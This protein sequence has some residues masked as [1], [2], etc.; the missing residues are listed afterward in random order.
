MGNG[1]KRLLAAL[2]ALAVSGGCSATG[3]EDERSGRN[4]GNLGDADCEVIP[5]FTPNFEPELAWEWTGSALAP[6]FKQVIMTPIVVEVNGD[7]IPDIVFSTFAGNELNDGVLRAISGDDGHDLWAVTN[8]SHSVKAGASIAAGDIDGDGLVEICGIPFNGRGIIC[9]EN[10]GTFKFRSAED[11]YDYNEWGGPSLADLDGDGTVEILDGNRVY[12]NTGALKWVGSDGMGGAQY[13]GPVSFGADIDQ[14]GTQELVNGRSIYK[15]DGTLLC[16][17]TDIP[18]GTAAVGNFD[19]D[20]QG[21][22]VVAGNGKVSL[23]DDNCALKW[24][25]TIPGGCADG[26]GGAPILADVDSDGLPEVAVSGDRAFSVFDTNGTLKWTSTIQDWSSGKAS[27]AVFDFEDDGQVELVFA[28]E[29]SLRIYNGATGQVRFETRHSSATTHENPVIADV[30]GDFAAD[31]VV[32]TNNTAYPP[33]NGIRVYHDR[34]EGWA[35]TRRIWNQSAYSITNVNNDG[36]IPAHPVSHWL[37]PKLNSFHG[38]A[39]NYLGEGDNPYAAVDLIAANVTASCGDGEFSG[40]LQLSA[41]VTNQGGVGV[42]AGVKVSF[43]RGNPASGGTLLGT[44]TLAEAIPAN[45]SV[46][47]SLTLGTVPAGS[48]EVFV[49]VDDNGSGTGRETECREDNNTA[50]ATVDLTCSPANVPPVALCQNVTVNADAQCQASASVDNGSHDP[51]QQPGP[52][53]VSQSPNGP[54]GLGSHNV[55]LTANDGADSAQCV[56]TVTVVDTTKPA[57]S[58]PPARVINTCAAAGSPVHYETPSS[59]NCGEAPVSCSHP[60]GSTFPPGTTAVSC[61]ATDGSG[62]ASTCGFDVTVV[63]DT[64]PPTITCPVSLDARIRL[65]EIGLVLDFTASATDDCGTPQMRCIPPPGS[66]FLLGLTPVA[67]TATDAA[68]NSASC[69]F[70]IRVS[71]DLSLP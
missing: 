32:A 41:Q 43:Y 44:A 48:A 28:D 65:G 53:S 57:V 8:P 33:Y 30:D 5:P 70:G 51:D 38:N 6:E 35:R 39:A 46:L 1:R 13:T 20:T 50:S 25:A 10:D 63:G 19:G 16:A 27:A 40:V 68:G 11:A 2:V 60:S 52:F 7:G 45:G 21:E 29:V 31:L 56:G 55:T 66:L 61:S 47:A 22:I 64:T 12:S 17:N 69:H 15:A 9:Y 54:F 67:C 18:H 4:T 42:A 71:V 36:S 59:D 24:T 37:R 23:L 62:N 14:D 49:V 3:S 58:C 34:L 26:C